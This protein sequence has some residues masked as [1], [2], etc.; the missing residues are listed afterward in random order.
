MSGNLF[1]KVCSV[2]NFTSAWL[3]IKE[4]DSAGGI[5]KISVYDFERNIDHNLTELIKD[6]ATENYM[7]EP[8]KKIL[9]QKGNEEYR[10]LGLLSVKDKIAQQAVKQVIEPLFEKKFLNVSYAYRPNKNTYKAIK[11]TLHHIVQEKRHWICLCDI[12]KYFD[13]ISH[14]LLLPRLNKVIPDDA[15]MR[16]IEIWLK[17]GKVN[18]SYKWNDVTS[19]VPQGGILSPLIS[20]FYL[21]PFDCEMVHN[22]YGY[23]RYADDFLVM[24]YTEKQANIAMN[25]IIKSLKNKLNLTLNN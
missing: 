6:I 23:V 15:V 21:H 2:E 13:N 12:D 1:K 11:R 22:R 5:D 25:I 17:I 9:I 7:P 18:E 19:G 20:N 4:K 16:L 10:E 24:T 8:N 14:E 3:K